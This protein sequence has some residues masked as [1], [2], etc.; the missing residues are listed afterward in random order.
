[1]HRPLPVC[2]MSEPGT[3]QGHTPLSSSHPSSFPL[4]P[5]CPSHHHYLLTLVTGAESSCEPLPVTFPSIRTERVW[6]GATGHRYCHLLARLEQGNGSQTPGSNP[7]SIVC[8]PGGRG[9]RL[10]R[11]CDSQKGKEKKELMWAEHL[12]GA[13]QCQTC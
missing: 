5:P 6:A 1:M 2:T 4:Q 12:W 7:F 11:L 8:F 9:R 10:A 3:Y 13:R